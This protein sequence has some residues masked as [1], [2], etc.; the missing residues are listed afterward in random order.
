MTPLFFPGPTWGKRKKQVIPK[1]LLRSRTR[2]LHNPRREYLRPSGPGRWSSSGRS[3]WPSRRSGWPA[4]VL[5]GCGVACGAGCV[6]VAL[7]WWL[8][9]WLCAVRPGLL[10]LSLWWPMLPAV[11]PACCAGGAGCGFCRDGGR[12][13]HGLGGAIGGRIEPW[14]KPDTTRIKPLGA[15]ILQGR[16]RSLHGLRP[17]SRRR[18]TAPPVPSPWRSPPPFPAD[19]SPGFFWRLCR[20]C[21]LPVACPA[22]HFCTDFFTEIF[23]EKNAGKLPPISGGC[24]PALSLPA[25]SGRLSLRLLLS[26]GPGP[27][28]APAGRSKPPENSRR[29]ILCSRYSFLEDYIFTPPIVP[30]NRLFPVKSP[31]NSPQILCKK[32][33][34]RPL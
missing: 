11:V 14:Y 25:D 2:R 19:F 16:R 27:G 12:L 9:W 5:A 20:W 17:C 4:V 22:C 8:C 24:L 23:H 1:K 6:A 3:P 30:Q 21:L 31:K 34:P 26:A 10:W 7:A 13:L 32:S 18:S 33:S 28:R 29:C 15:A